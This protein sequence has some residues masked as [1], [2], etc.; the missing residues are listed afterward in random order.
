MP[1]SLKRLQALD[2]EGYIRDQVGESLTLEFK[3]EL[4]LSS[5]HDK[6]E[7]AKD[8]SGMANA[9]GGQI[10]YGIE[11]AEVGDTGCKAAKALHPLADSDL[12]ERLDNVLASA[13]SPRVRVRLYTVN[14][15]NGLCLVADVPASDYDLHMVSAYG[16]TRY[17]RRTEKAVRPMTEPEVAQAYERIERLKNQASLHVEEIVREELPL[18][19][20]ASTLIIPMGCGQ[21]SLDVPRFLARLQQPGLN[22]A[23][24]CSGGMLDHLLGCLYPYGGGLQAAVGNATF[25]DSPTSSIRIRLDGAIHCSDPQ[26]QQSF[27][28]ARPLRQVHDACVL[29]RFVW[30]E[31]NVHGPFKVVVRIP[32]ASTEM[33]A[34]NIG[35]VAW[36]ELHLRDEKQ[37]ISIESDSTT[38]DSDFVMSVLRKVMDR[39]WHYMGQARCPWFD[40]NG[41][42]NQRLVANVL[43]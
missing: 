15:A 35:D 24:G 9:R 25:W 1:E 23:I 13:I 41:I 31:M 28:L 14:V 36:R 32:L 10:I 6:R 16:E 27:H 22:D 37:L 40:E 42:L 38:R 4:N 26:S 8:V 29:A 2:L 17:Y 5:E 34:V 3:R 20:R 43:R 19:P 21:K 39:L 11:D 33:K 30:G 18:N 12:V 7:A